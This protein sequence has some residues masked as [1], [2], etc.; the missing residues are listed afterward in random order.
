MKR[1]ILSL[2]TLSF[3]LSVS[4]FVFTAC[5]GGDSHEHAYTETIIGPTCAEQGYTKHEC[6][7]GDAYED[8]FVSKI[9]HTLNADGECSTCTATASAGLK[10][11][12]ASGKQ[13]V[14]GLGT[15]TGKEVIIP[16]SVNGTLVTDINTTAFKNKEIEAVYIPYTVKTIGKQAFYGCSA[17]KKVVFYGDDESQ[18]ES[19]G[20]G[21]FKNC[22][23]LELTELNGGLYL[24]IGNT[25]LI[26][27][28]VQDE[29]ATSLSVVDGTKII[30]EN[31]ADRNENLTEV[32]LPGSIKQMGSEAFYQS[33]NIKT[34]N[35]GGNFNDWASIKFIDS[36][37]PH[38][39][40]CGITT[41][42]GDVKSLTLS[43]ETI[44][45]YAFNNFIDI[46]SLTL[47]DSVKS[48]GEKAFFGCY[49]M[50]DLKI[51]KGLE[52][53]GEQAFEDCTKL[54]EVCNDSTLNITLG[55]TENGHVSAYAKNI[56]SSTK[57]VSK[58]VIKDN[59][60]T[61]LDGKDN[62]LVDYVGT[63]EV[64]TIP[65]NV[66]IVGD[67]ALYKKS[68]ITKLNIT[69]G[70]IH[71]GNHAF[72][73]LNQITEITL[74]D[75]L[76][77]IGN[78]SFEG[79]SKA[80]VIN[81]SKTRTLETI[82]DYA[83]ANCSSLTEAILPDGLKKTGNYS[84]NLC[85]NLLLFSMPASLEEV[86]WYMVNGCY[87]CTELWFRGIEGKN[88]KGVGFTEMLKPHGKLWWNWYYQ[89]GTSKVK[90]PK[91]NGVEYIEYD[92]EV[93]HGR[94]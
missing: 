20:D 18:L 15:Y 55:T 56:Y 80:E 36:Y 53:I 6:S 85:S 60:Y 30:Y 34:V 57:G 33:P 10:I 4:L 93:P 76:K 44:N 39:Y 13:S 8:N 78:N 66:Q 75:S 49:K 92:F 2:L 88:E 27:M 45:D 28:S 40:A 90:Y 58:Y 7:C 54:Y 22:G 84:F 51:G 48:V 5:G 72:A 82:G 16:S 42:D 52:N 11:N 94:G 86:S 46:E 41:E 69:E 61:M 50:R 59:F 32:S 3:I 67:Y 31:S 81:F 83:F 70:V 29:S 17:L 14:R 24:T 23:A 47:T 87:K 9:A 37:S 74:P 1:K 89:C 38:Y 19:L 68:F 12:L 25:P 73:G 26:F 62:I 64:V 91:A 63:D 43:A 21:V 79:C 35:F 77:T 71:I 65:S